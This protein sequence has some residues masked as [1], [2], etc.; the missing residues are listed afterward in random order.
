MVLDVHEPPVIE[1]GAITHSPASL[2]GRTGS[3]TYSV[4]VPGSELKYKWESL[5]PSGAAYHNSREGTLY[6]PGALYANIT[7][8]GNVFETRNLSALFPS[9]ASGYKTRVRITNSHNCVT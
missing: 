9:L 3:V 6:Q 7:S 2:C 4:T 8:D 1:G 5:P